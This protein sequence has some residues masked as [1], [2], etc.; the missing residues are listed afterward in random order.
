MT[1]EWPGLDGIQRIISLWQPDPQVSDALL[2][3]QAGKLT[4][5]RKHYFVLLA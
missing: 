2:Q 4:G 5:F 3:S 1:I